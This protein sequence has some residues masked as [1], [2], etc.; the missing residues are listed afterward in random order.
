MSKKRRIKQRI[1]ASYTIGQL[2]RKNNKELL[3]IAKVLGS[4][5]ANLPI[6]SPKREGIGKVVLY[7]RSIL[8][9]RKHAAI[10]TN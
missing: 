5:Y 8:Q 9:E 3:V 10:R 4:Q 6:D 1:K 7:I 2:Q